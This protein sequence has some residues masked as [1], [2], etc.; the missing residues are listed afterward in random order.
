MV[1]RHAAL[2]RTLSAAQS[3][4]KRNFQKLE[5]AIKSP[6]WVFSLLI[7]S[8][9]GRSLHASKEQQLSSRNVLTVHSC[10][11][12]KSAVV[13]SRL[14]AQWPLPKKVRL[15]RDCTAFFCEKF[16]DLPPADSWLGV[17]EWW[18][19]SCPLNWGLLEWPVDLHFWPWCQFS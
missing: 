7:F 18:R 11:P 2:V 13:E 8:S 17:Q 5:I 4:F 3:N 1:S 9:F 10:N 19:W 16:G 15:Y 6:S 12:K 14:D